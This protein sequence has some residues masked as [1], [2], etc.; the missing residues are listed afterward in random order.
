MSM[1]SFFKQ[2]MFVMT[3][4]MKLKGMHNNF[5]LYH[6]FQAHMGLKFCYKPLRS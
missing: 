4:L 6:S 3:V 2:T 5:L 1:N